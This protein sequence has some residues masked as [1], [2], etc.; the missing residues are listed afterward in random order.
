[1]Q[2][3]KRVVVVVGEDDELMVGERPGV[4]PREQAV[5]RQVRR[6]DV[7]IEPVKGAA[8]S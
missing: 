7:P 5:L 3:P 8:H 1:M 4:E 6:C 2:D